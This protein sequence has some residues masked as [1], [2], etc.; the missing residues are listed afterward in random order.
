M[1]EAKLGNKFSKKKSKKGGDEDESPV[2]ARA[3]EF[4]EA[5]F[6]TIVMAITTIFALVGDDLRVWFTDSNADPLFYSLLLISLVLFT[7]EI[8]INSCVVDEFKYSF[9]F[10]L[11]LIATISLIP[12]ILW[13]TVYLEDVM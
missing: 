12:D 10:W 8:L 1:E 3:R 2:R 9:F 11:D 5:K 6:V 13:L 7:T 4:V